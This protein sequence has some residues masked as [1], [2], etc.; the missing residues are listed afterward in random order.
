[1]TP[2]TFL[3]SLEIL[4]NS[5]GIVLVDKYQPRYGI[6]ERCI[7]WRNFKG[8][9]NW[10][11][12]YLIT[13]NVTSTEKEKIHE[14]VLHGIE[15]RINERILIGNFCAMRTNMKLRKDTI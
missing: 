11:V 14:T 2:C 10:R 7:Y 15:A 1:M 9:N 13:T 6:N 5:R 4:K 12:V 8:Y 3:T